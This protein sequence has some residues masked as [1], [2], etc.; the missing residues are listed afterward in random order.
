MLALLGDRGA[1]PSPFRSDEPGGL[2]RVL[3]R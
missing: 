1:A 2:A 3:S